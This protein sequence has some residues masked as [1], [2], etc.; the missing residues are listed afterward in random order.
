MKYRTIIQIC[1]AWAVFFM[2]GV[3]LVAEEKAG[4]GGW[5]KEHFP[6]GVED[7]EGKPVGLDTLKGKVIGV[8][9]SAH[10]C[11]PCRRFT[12]ALVKYRNDNKDKF[13]VVF[14]SSDKSA[15]AQKK[16]MAEAKMEWPTMEW[17]SDAAS[18]LKKKYA[19]RGIPKLILL[20]QGGKVITADGRG[21]VSQNIDMK[22]L[23]A[24]N[25][26]VKTEEYNCGKC[27]K[28]HT[29]ERIEVKTE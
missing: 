29:R 10:W 28:T 8:Y 7:A 16:Y 2:A 23:H 25:Y 13:E 18:E 4:E 5:L 11:G 17:N 6:N 3:G 14:V 15:E 24:G 27:S 19:V 22:A 9:F 21:L 26:T 1:V 20:S 12:P